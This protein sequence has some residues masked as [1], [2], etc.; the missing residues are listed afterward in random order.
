[1]ESLIEWVCDFSLAPRASRATWELF[2]C[3]GPLFCCPSDRFSM[4]G[5]V[6][7]ADVAILVV[8]DGWGSWSLDRETCKPALAIELR[9]DSG[10]ADCLR[11]ATESGGLEMMVFEGPGRGLEIATGSLFD[12]IK[13]AMDNGW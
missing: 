10:L 5:V 3:S 1:M 13:A 12:C 11:N 2:C 4:V 8:D 9:L 7:A 6:A